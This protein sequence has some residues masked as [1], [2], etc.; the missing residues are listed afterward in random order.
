MANSPESFTFAFAAGGSGGATGGG[1]GN[2][3]GTFAIDAT[4]GVITVL[5]VTTQLETQGT[6]FSLQVVATDSRLLAGAAAVVTVTVVEKN[7][8]P[9]FTA[10]SSTAPFKEVAENSRGVIEM[11]SFEVVDTD[12]NYPLT[13]KVTGTDPEGYVEESCVTQHHIYTRYI[14][15]IHTFIADYAPMCTHYTCIYT[16]YT[17]LNTSKHPKYTTTR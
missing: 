8:I 14:P 7:F 13:M 10:A 12:K 15:F 1:N 6:V 4:T 11:G 5:K 16:I 17:P 2:L 3:G 9:M